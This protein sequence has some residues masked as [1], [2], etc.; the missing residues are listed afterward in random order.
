MGE[1][2]V[3]NPTLADVAFIV[4]DRTFHAHRIALLASSNAFRAMFNGGYKERD[5]RSIEIPNIRYDVF[6]LMMRYT[7][8]GQVEVPV[9]LAQDLLKA[10]D[11]YLLEG[12]KRLC[13]EAISDSISTENLHAIYE[14]SES[15]NAPQLGS[16]CVMFILERSQEMIEHHGI[17]RF[18][19]LAAKMAPQLRHS[20]TKM[21][22]STVDAPKE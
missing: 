4:E 10:S 9:E 16:R 19:V 8:T 20:L 15:F 6:E 5:A 22:E 12:L 18:L 3:N 7:Y 14:L 17:Q 2:Y 1:E 21:L 13:E 11:Q